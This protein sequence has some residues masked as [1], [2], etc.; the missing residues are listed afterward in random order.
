MG[1]ASFFRLLSLAAIWGASFLFTRISAPVLGPTILIESRVGLAA[2]FLL[3]A[4]V[5]LRKP[6]NFRQ[7]WKHYC[8]VGALNAALPFLLFAFAAQTL[9]AS[10]LSI[11]NAS[12][13]LWGA[14]IG[15]LLARRLPDGLTL[16]GLLL[17]IAGV[18]LVVGLGHFARQ[19]GAPLAIAAALLAPFMYGV[20]T[21]YVR[22]AKAVD[23]FSNALGAMSAATLLIMPALPFAST[24]APVSAGIVLDVIILG[25]LCTGAT[26]LLYF[27]LV[28]EIGATSTLTVTYLIP[29]FGILW[30]HLFLGESVTLSMIAGSCVIILG[31]ALVTRFNPAAVLLRRI[32]SNA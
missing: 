2:L 13:P 20:A 31:T 32:N 27:R 17:G 21:H 22:T 12:A 16:I 5:L 15:A 1:I 11:L 29:I 24:T 18:G 30:G 6:L 3:G 9:T 25:I 8:I 4:A 10:A 23:G 14:A 7:H 28:K 26:F 19:H